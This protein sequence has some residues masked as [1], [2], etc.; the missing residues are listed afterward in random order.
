MGDDC[1]N[2][3]VE[4]IMTTRAMRRFTDEPVAD[5]EMVT[6]VRAAQH[7]PSG[8][9]LQPQQYVVV[10]NPGRRAAVAH[11]YGRAF[12]RSDAVQVEPAHRDADDASTWRRSRASAHH[13]AD[14][15]AIVL[16]LQ[17]VV[18]WVDRDRTGSMDVGRI[19][20]S[21][22]PAVQNICV[23]DRSFGLATVLTTVIRIHGAEVLDELGVPPGHFEIAALVP[24]GRPAGQFG[25]APRRRA[26]TV[27]H[28]DRWQGRRQAQ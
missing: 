22:Y 18:D 16:F 28:W 7:A 14:S 27:T 26:D 15:P 6:C 9:N 20:A 2:A 13:L 3:V 1:P 11:W 10:T 21:V 5:D 19:D 23:A 24:V 25:R 8:G 12:R 4:A 17:P